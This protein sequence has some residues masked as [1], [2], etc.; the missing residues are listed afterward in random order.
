[1]VDCITKIPIVAADEPYV[2][3]VQMIIEGNYILT[4][5]L[6]RQMFDSAVV[7][8]SSEELVYTTKRI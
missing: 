8:I 2:R 6:G 5:K 1:M 7:K 4:G 3:D